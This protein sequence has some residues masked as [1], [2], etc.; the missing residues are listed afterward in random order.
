[1]PYLQISLCQENDLNYPDLSEGS[2]S[3]RQNLSRGDITDRTFSLIW[4]CMLLGTSA[5]FVALD[6]FLASISISPK[7]FSANWPPFNDPLF[8]P[9]FGIILIPLWGLL[10]TALSTSSWDGKKVLFRLPCLHFL[11]IS[12]PYLSPYLFISVRISCQGVCFFFSSILCF[13]TFFPFFP[14]LTYSVFP[15]PTDQKRFHFALPLFSV[16]SRYSF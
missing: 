6:R 13:L 5:L 11:A 16:S 4:S 10:Y 2:S 12:I 7:I 14:Y 3:Q 15:F 8:R 1:L 9:I